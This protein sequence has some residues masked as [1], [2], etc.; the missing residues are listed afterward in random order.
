M[1]LYL[2]IPTNLHATVPI[3]NVDDIFTETEPDFVNKM[4][5]YNS[6]FKAQSSIQPIYK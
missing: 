4:Y 1:D 2:H 6:K 5:L 3:K